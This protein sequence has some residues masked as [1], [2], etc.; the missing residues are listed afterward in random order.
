M[1]SVGHGSWA[2]WPPRLP[3]GQKW[4]R[5]PVRVVT[6]VAKMWKNNSANAIAESKGG[7]VQTP[8][9]DESGCAA[10]EH[11]V[12]TMLR[13]KSA[14]GKVHEL[15]RTV[16]SGCPVHH[17]ETL[18][19]WIITD[20]HDVREALKDRRF[21][22][23]YVRQMD[24]RRPDWRD[25]PALALAA[26]LMLSMD[27]LEHDRLR[28]IGLRRV[29][30]RLV[31]R[32]T[33]KIRAIVD[34][35][36]E[37]FARNGGGDFVHDVA[38]RLTAEVIS[39][40]MGISV[41]DLDWYQ[42]AVADTLLAFNPGAT[43]EEM[44][45]ADDAALRV[46][47]HWRAIVDERIAEPRDDLVSELLAEQDASTRLTP[48]EVAA[49]S[50]FLFSAGFDTT[51]HTLGMGMLAF[52]EHP[53]ELHRLRDNPQL[54]ASMAEEVLRFTTTIVGQPR[55]TSEVIE[56]EA[57]RIPGEQLVFCALAGANRDPAAYADPDR[58]D[59]GREGPTHLTFGYGRHM[60]LG[61]PLA[62]AEVQMVFE[63]VA[64][65]FGNATLAGEP[66][67]DTKLSPRGLRELRLRVVS[68]EYRDS[69][70]AT[71]K[72]R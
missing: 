60:C 28:R 11:A 33:A 18:Q 42:V 45:R 43:D 9:A 58:F 55:F 38:F 17:S 15:L 37:Q 22:V 68:A 8:A 36:L 23:D 16:R 35:V 59:I 34:S 1:N 71:S 5:C 7:R 13:D 26:D 66:E 49:F 20:Y 47:R 50:E 24:I 30:T 41:G 46:R 14:R 64:R 65:W 54:G 69:T 2:T 72:V 67:W 21:S 39:D 27:G 44:Q 32:K 12:V 3:H 63:A 52:I 51:V 6:A 4:K 19:Q 31:E 57:A 10:A 61:A 53:H 70:A 48:D 25:H 62:R 29:N 56:L 40:I